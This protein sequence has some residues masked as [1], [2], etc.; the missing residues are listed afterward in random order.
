MGV[1]TSGPPQDLDACDP[2]RHVRTMA[3]AL[4]CWIGRHRWE[5]RRNPEAGGRDAMY[6]VCSRCGAERKQYGPP[7]GTSLGAGGG[8]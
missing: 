1:L 4:S 6:E 3:K 2:A 5:Q 7:S 8:A